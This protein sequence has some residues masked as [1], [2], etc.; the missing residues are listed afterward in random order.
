VMRLKPVAKYGDEKW[1]YKKT[2][3]RMSR[4]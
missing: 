1:K 4:S 3:S 2:P